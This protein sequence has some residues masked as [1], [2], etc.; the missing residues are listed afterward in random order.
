MSCAAPERLAA[1]S[2][3]AV[4]Y[5]FDSILGAATPAFMTERK[6]PPPDCGVSRNCINIQP[7]GIFAIRPPAID[8]SS[9]WR[10]ADGECNGMRLRPRVA[11]G[12]GTGLFPGRDAAS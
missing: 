11:L 1:I 6:T 7:A 2:C 12:K 4:I 5:M 9:F 8:V 3:F 10:L